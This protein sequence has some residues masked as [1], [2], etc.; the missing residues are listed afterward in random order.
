M[1]PVEKFFIAREKAEVIP[2]R[3]SIEIDQR[4]FLPRIIHGSLRNSAHYRFETLFFPKIFLAC[5]SQWNDGGNFQ[6][7]SARGKYRNDFDSPNFRPESPLTDQ[8][9][10]FRMRIRRL[11][12]FHGLINPVYVTWNR[13]IPNISSL[14]NLEFEL[15]WNPDCRE[16]DR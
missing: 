3:P 9:F 15:T 6:S 13:D 14:N 8:T 4:N 16:D 10:F 11:E 5:T 12:N 1:I 7:R 2:L